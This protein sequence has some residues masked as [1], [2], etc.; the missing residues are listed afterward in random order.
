[1]NSKGIDYL[2]ERMAMTIIFDSRNIRKNYNS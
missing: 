1:M 2:I